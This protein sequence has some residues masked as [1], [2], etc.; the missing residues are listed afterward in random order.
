MDVVVLATTK[1]ESADLA[2]ASKTIFVRCFLGARIG[3]RKRG[4]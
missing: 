1:K 4:I 3:T 2:S